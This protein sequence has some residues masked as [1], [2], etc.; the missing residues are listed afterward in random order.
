[1]P[2]PATAYSAGV[3]LRADIDEPAKLEPG[4]T[5]AIPTGIA[6]ALPEGWEAQVRPRSGL[7]LKYSLG[8]LNAPGTI[9]SDYRG[10]IKILLTNFGKDAYTLN[11]GDRIAQLVLAKVSRPAWI[12]VG[13]LP[14]SERGGGGFGHSGSS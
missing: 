1:M 14:D 6:I 12:E 4:Q 3:D 2:T 5:V 10:E 11:P 7:A 8:M 9:D 13:K